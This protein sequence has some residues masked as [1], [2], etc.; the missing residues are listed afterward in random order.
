MSDP[1][2]FRREKAKRVTRND[3]WSVEDCLLD[4][5]EDVRS[6]KRKANA[7]LVLFLDNG[8]ERYDTGWQAA[9]V[10]GSQM[11]A[12]MEAVKA[13]ILRDMGFT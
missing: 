6:G 8:D 12:L 10:S 1:V 3:E 4:A 2:D 5:I 9:N 11:V 7:V 13:T